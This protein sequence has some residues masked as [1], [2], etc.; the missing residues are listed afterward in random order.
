ML[1]GTWMRRS[2]QDARLTVHLCCP[3]P[4]FLVRRRRERSSLATR[5]RCLYGACSDE[6]H[7]RYLSLTPAHYLR[8]VTEL[9]KPLLKNELNKLRR[10]VDSREKELDKELAADLTRQRVEVVASLY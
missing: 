10:R 2:A 3:P 5:A 7:E 9:S 6:R 4:D 1:R 8:Q